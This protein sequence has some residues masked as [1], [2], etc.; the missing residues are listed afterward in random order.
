MLPAHPSCHTPCCS[1]PCTMQHQACVVRCS[2]F[3]HCPAWCCTCTRAPL[4]ARCTRGR[5]A[6]AGNSRARRQAGR[7]VDEFE[8]L[9]SKVMWVCA[10]RGNLEDKPA[11]ELCL[12]LCP[13]YPVT[14]L[15]DLNSIQKVGSVTTA[16]AAPACCA[17]PC[18]LQHHLLFH[19]CLVLLS[20]PDS[21]LCLCSHLLLLTETL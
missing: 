13:S 4:P 11:V 21:L 2:C 15:M 6:S 10:E 12:C 19:L 16:P 3:T 20:S 8:V 7:K 1:G 5:Y 18:S 17:V 9:R 14:G